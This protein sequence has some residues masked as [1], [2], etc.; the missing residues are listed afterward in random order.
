MTP[1]RAWMIAH[2]I[3]MR[4]AADLG[5]YAESNRLHVPYERADGSTFERT[6]VFPGGD[7][8]QPKGEPL[9]LYWPLGRARHASVL[10][11]EGEGDTLAAASV[12]HSTPDPALNGLCPVGLPGASMNAE[13]VAEEL[14]ATEARVVYLALDNDD[15]GERATQKLIPELARRRMTP[16]PLVFPY[17]DLSEALE[18]HLHHPEIGDV[19]DGF[20]EH[21][22]REAREQCDPRCAEAI[23]AAA[24][25]KLERGPR[26]GEFKRD[27]HL[28]TIPPTVYIER[29]T[30]QTPERGFVSCPL[31]DHDDRTPSCKVWDDPS[32]GWFCYGCDR[33]GTIYDLAAG[34]YN[35]PTTGDG[36][37]EIRRRLEEVFPE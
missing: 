18:A 23:E 20:L 15:A 31:P 4:L 16:A 34:F 21:A 11:C 10:L 6:R 28:D 22:I 5:L 1:I 17:K 9:C 13:R 35:L 24:R 14:A 26:H 27:G 7:F 2:A 8:I 36:F 12:L 29:L 19:R 33:G 3:D 25:A 30:G 32:K 37:K